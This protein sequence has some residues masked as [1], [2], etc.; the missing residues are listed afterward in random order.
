MIVTLRYKTKTKIDQKLI[1]VGI[2]NYNA[3]NILL[4]FE[5]PILISLEVMWVEKSH[6]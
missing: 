5:S 3:S 2:V 4:K 6:P 1:F